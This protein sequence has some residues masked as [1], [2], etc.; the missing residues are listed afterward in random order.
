MA[1]GL[2]TTTH[3]GRRRTRMIRI[4]RARQISR[5]YKLAVQ[6]VNRR[7]PVVRAN[8][9]IRRILKRY[10]DPGRSILGRK[11]GLRASERKFALLDKS[12]DRLSGRARDRRGEAQLWARRPFLELVRPPAVNSLE[13]DPPNVGIVDRTAK[14]RFDLLVPRDCLGWEGRRRT[15]RERDGIVWQSTDPLCDQSAVPERMQV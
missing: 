10:P 15:S 2:P 3:L 7:S 5:P 1:L 9:H 6:L 11:H 13:H 4:V 8:R 14:S 12:A